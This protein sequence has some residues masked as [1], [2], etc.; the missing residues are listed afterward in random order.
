MKKYPP[1]SPVLI[2]K[3]GK[4]RYV[5]QYK[6]EWKDGKSRSSWR[7]SVGRLNDDDTVI[8]SKKFLKDNPVYVGAHAFWSDYRICFGEDQKL[9][10]KVQTVRQSSVLNAG[11]CY[12]LRQI[13]E[14][15]GITDDLK[16]SFPE[17]WREIL[18]LSIFLILHPGEELSNY[19]TIASQSYF[20]TGPIT[21]QRISEI[22][23]LINYDQ[24][25]EYM[26][27]RINNSKTLNHEGFWAFDTTSIS[28]Y[29]K[30]N[31]MVAW[32]HNKE[33][34]RLPQINLALL[35][36]EI[37]GEPICYRVLNG[38]LNDAVLL[39]NLLIQL[40]GLDCDNI[41]L[42]LDRGFYSQENL[43]LFYA[44]DIEFIIGA[45]TNLDL[46]RLA[47]Q[48]LQKDL[49]DCLP[50]L[51]LKGEA[52]F[53]KT[54][55]TDWGFD[56]KLQGKKQTP[57]FVHVY[58][59]AHKRDDETLAMSLRIQEII[60]TLKDAKN[61]NCPELARF[62]VYDPN[63][64][65]WS[66]SEANWH[67]FREQTGFFFLFSNCVS[68]PQMALDIYRGK[69]VIEK[70]FNNYKDRCAGRRL[71]CQEGAMEGKIFVVYLGLSILLRL[72]KLV[73]RSKLTLDSIP[74]L[75][76]RLAAIRLFKIPGIE[77]NRYYWQ[78]ISKSQRELIE[79]AGASVPD[80]IVCI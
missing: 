70:A 19:E 55:E 61:C 54:F 17:N 33:N 51:Q 71:R 58:F 78:E 53:G 40:S 2:Q 39:K 69:D 65:R 12:V 35:L 36:D 9:I 18:S 11:D 59:D 31:R 29:S 20:P 44:Q 45:K 8:F 28:S 25:M 80:T 34:D 27:R 6:N 24:C 57:L 30:A 15:S 32:G 72:K 50:T 67:E 42:V 62:F 1:I 41:R 22:L 3:N 46:V 49:T 48:R 38:S 10:E 7:K 76:H 16:S 47:K 64:K 52:C 56:T 5:L 23:Q 4:T 75:L 26:K 21:S 14:Q 74:D 77:D 63:T 60:T 73:D 37:S 79:L 43:S 68:D 66:F 13:A